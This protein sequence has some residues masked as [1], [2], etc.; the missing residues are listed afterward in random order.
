MTLLTGPNPFDRGNGMTGC[1]TNFAVGVLV[2]DPAYGTAITDETI[3]G[4][5]PIRWP[6]GYTGRLLGSDVV[7]FD[8]SGHAVAKTGN[9]YQIE[10]A[11]VQG[12]P[13]AWLACGYVLLK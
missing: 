2:V 10:G 7:V 1:Y 6:S 13:R 3:G 12:P 4:T 9:R 5:G 8:S 11:F